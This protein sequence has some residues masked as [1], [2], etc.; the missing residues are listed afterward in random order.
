MLVLAVDPGAVSG[1]SAYDTRDGCFQSWEGQVPL[2]DLKHYDAVVIEGFLITENT[3]KLTQ[4]RDAME[5]IGQVKAVCEAHDIP[6]TIQMPSAKRFAQPNKLQLLGWYKKTRDN[7]ANDAAAQLLRFLTKEKLLH[8][9]D[10]NKLK[11]AL[12]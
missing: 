6:L 12:R 10:K 1:I 5:I 2:E 7:H 11:G 8:A 9:D 4:Q 3:S